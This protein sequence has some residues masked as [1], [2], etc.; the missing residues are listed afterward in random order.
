MDRVSRREQCIENNRKYR[1]RK[2]KE[3]EYLKKMEKYFIEHNFES[4]QNFVQE[5]GQ[6][7]FDEMIKDLG[8]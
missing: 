4:Y 8:L 1:I 6:E 2:K 7:Q 3:L 5:N